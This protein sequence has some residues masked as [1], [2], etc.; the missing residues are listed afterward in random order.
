M[1][2]SEKRAAQ[3]VIKVFADAKKLCKAE[4]TLLKSAHKKSD[5]DNAAQA[6]IDV[7][8]SSLRYLESQALYQSTK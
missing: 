2:L 8:N 6:L 5:F 1:K 7:V 3:A 4:K